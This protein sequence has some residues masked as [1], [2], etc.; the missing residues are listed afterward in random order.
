MMKVGENRIVVH[1]IIF[2][3]LE[4]EKNRWQLDCLSIRIWSNRRVCQSERFLCVLMIELH[5]EEN[6]DR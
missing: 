1:T 3:I 4:R 5:I 6:Q 2:V